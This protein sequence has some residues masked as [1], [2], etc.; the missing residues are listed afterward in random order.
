VARIPTGQG[1]LVAYDELKCDSG[2]IVVSGYSPSAV[3]SVCTLVM[4]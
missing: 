1:S 4:F 3:A 2:D